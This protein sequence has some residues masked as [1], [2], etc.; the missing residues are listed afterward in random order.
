VA[1]F[2]AGH[3]DRDVLP[4]VGGNRF[5]RLAGCFRDRSALAEPL[6]RQLGACRPA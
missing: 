4:D 2:L 3:F 6:I 5:I 1:G